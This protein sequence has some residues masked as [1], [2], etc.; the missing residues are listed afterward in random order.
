MIRRIAL[1]TAGMLLVSG[2]A[3]AQA[4]ATANATV[5][6]LEELAILNTQQLDFGILSVNADG[7]YAVNA[8]GTTNGATVTQFGT[9]LPASFAITG[10]V[11]RAF[12]VTISNVVAT[13]TNG[14]NTLTFLTNNNW[15]SCLSCQLDGT[16][17]ATVNVGGRISLVDGMVGGIYEAAGG[18]AFTVTV[19]Y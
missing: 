13:L 4:T 18:E 5:E 6:I 16:G 14:T 10:T 17:A 2:L 1:L 15:A 3:F 8:D 9:P 12:S 11:N 7:N 19:A